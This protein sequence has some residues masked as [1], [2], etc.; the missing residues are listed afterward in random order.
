MGKPRRQ[1]QDQK[2]PE[3]E[4]NAK[5]ENLPGYY[6]TKPK[7][8]T[9]AQHGQHHNQKRVPEVQIEETDQKKAVTGFTFGKGA[10]AKRKAIQRAARITI[11]LIL[12]ADMLSPT[13]IFFQ[14]LL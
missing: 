13:S 9:G 5:T 3:P 4:K 12:L 14:I 7:N 8:E 11:W 6:Q 1:G 10:K 2:P